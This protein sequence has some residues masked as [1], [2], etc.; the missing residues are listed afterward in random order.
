M[1]LDLLAGTIFIIASLGGLLWT[2]MI[3]PRREKGTLAISK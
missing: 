3:A 2:T 1:T